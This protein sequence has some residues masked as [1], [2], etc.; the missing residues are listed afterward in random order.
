MG[1]EP[2]KRKIILIIAF[3]LSSIDFHNDVLKRTRHELAGQK[4]AG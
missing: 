2:N 4:N 1:N 3:C